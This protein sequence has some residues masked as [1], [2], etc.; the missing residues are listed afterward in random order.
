LQ[1]CQERGIHTCLETSGFASQRRYAQVLPLT[2]IFLF[3][4][5]AAQP[6]AHQA[7]TGV[8]NVQILSNLDFLSSQGAAIMLR[9]PLIPGVNDSLDHLKGIANLGYKYPNLLGIELMPYHDLGKTKGQRLGE[10][11]PLEHVK[12]A[13]AATQQGWL[14]TLAGL[15]CDKAVMG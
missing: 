1:A 7:W 11:Y 5:K 9:C 3:D 4:Y 12:T 13:D 10:A 6:S 14:E 8:S 15:G 2:D